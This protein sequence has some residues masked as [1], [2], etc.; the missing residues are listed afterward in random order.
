MKFSRF[1]NVVEAKN[2]RLA[3]DGFKGPH[4]AL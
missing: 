3:L 2:K 1:T 4:P